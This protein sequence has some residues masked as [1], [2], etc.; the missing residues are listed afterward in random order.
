MLF[1]R[2]TLILMVG[3][4]M[5]GCRKAPTILDNSV[6]VV[7]PGVGIS[8]LCELGMTF[9]QIK[10]RIGGASTH[11]YYDN[12]F[13]WRRF[14]DGRR[15]RF[16]LIPSLGA[17]APLG[18]GEPVAYVTFFLRPYRDS[19]FPGLN[20]LE[21]FQGKL[22]NGLSFKD[23]T[24]SKVEVEKLFGNVSKVATNAAEGTQL[25]LKGQRFSYLRGD[26]SEDLWY[27]EQGIS[28]NLASNVV[29]SFQVF[30]ARGTNTK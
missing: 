7:Q 17:V 22:N 16:A 20:V 29:T 19:Q 24:V 10:K 28:F 18:N 25:R 6:I 26:N 8:N 27:P 12:T 30:K 21:P 1:S 9:S 4:L 14:T 11:G 3:C 2:A 13:S 23:R 15:G 5:V